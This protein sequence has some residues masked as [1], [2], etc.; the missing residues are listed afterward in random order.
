MTSLSPQMSQNVLH[1]RR[2]CL[3][4]IG[5]TAAQAD[6][7]AGHA[8]FDDVVCNLK[9]QSAVDVSNLVECFRLRNRTRKT[10]EDENRSCSRA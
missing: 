3:N 8:L 4:V 10:V 7:A 5:C 2:I 1:A 9:G 6:T